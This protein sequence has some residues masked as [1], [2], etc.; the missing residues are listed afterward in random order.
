MMALRSPLYSSTPTASSSAR[1]TTGAP[2][3]THSSDG[4][5]EVFVADLMVGRAPGLVGKGTSGTRWPRYCERW[6]SQATLEEVLEPWTWFEAEPVVVELIAGL[7]AAGIGCHLA[8][9]QQ[10]YRRAIMQD[11]RSVR[12]MVR[13]VLLFVRPRAWPSRTRRTSARSSYAT[14][15]PRRRCCSSTTTKQRR[16]RPLDRHQRRGLR[17]GHG[18]DALA[19]C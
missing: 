14:R 7:R 8:T 3:C 10:A 11:E 1:P 12:R 18:T 17:P 5:G 2:G 4:D 16:G 15:R 6:N 19:S 9:N 13:P